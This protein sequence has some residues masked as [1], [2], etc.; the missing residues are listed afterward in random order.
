[1]LTTARRR[2]PERCLSIPLNCPR[3]LFEEFGL[4]ADT[5]V[6]AA[7]GGCLEKVARAQIGKC[8]SRVYG[9]RLVQPAAILHIAAA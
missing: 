5:M 2:W 3:Q 4:P 8:A 1:M 9:G 6:P 7:N